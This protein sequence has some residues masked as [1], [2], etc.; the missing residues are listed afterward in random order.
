M[1]AFFIQYSLAIVYFDSKITKK[2][3]LSALYTT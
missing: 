3:N 1:I 2:L